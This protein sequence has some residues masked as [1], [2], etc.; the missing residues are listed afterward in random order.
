MYICQHPGMNFQQVDFFVL[1]AIFISSNVL[2]SIFQIASLPVVIL[3]PLGAV[4]LLW[5]ALFAR[6][7]LGDLF[8]KHMPGG[9]LFIVLGAIFLVVYAI[10]PDPPHSLLAL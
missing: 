7:I 10:H 4:S 9:P 2:G 1:E 8:S 5:N 6:M 3:A